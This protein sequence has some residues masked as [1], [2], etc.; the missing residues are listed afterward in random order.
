MNAHILATRATSNPRPA[1]RRQ[2]RAYRPAMEG[3]EQRLQLSAQ[4]VGSAVSNIVKI[5]PPGGPTGNPLP[6]ALP[7]AELAVEAVNVQSLGNNQFEVTAT[8]EDVPP[9]PP[10]LPNIVGIGGGGTTPISGLTYP[11]GGVLTITRSD[12]GTSLSLSSS[13]TIQSSPDPS[14]T[15]ASMPIP[16]LAPGQTVKLS[17]TTTGPALFTATAGPKIYLGRPLPF[18]VASN[19]TLSAIADNLVSHTLPVNTATLAAISTLNNAI[20][21]TIIS[22]DGN[23]SSIFIPGIVNEQFKLPGKSVSIGV[24]PISHTV[25]FTTNNLNS[26][27]AALTYEQGGLAITINFADGTNALVSN[28]VIAPNIGVTNLQV[29]IVFPLSYNASGQFF[30]LNSPKVTV[31]GNWSADGVLGP[32]FN[33]LLP[34]INAAIESA[35]IS[36]LQ[37]YLGLISFQL[38]KPLHAY[39]ASGRIVSANIQQ[40]QM[41]LTIETP[42]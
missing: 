9:L 33:L 41:L 7:E 19:S 17:T 12:G 24:G 3:M 37:P 34:N 30:N 22:L 16:S 21:N 38:D 13:N 15:L 28:S 14:Q 1:S 10:H 31:T 39:T 29:K 5:N 35:V 25:T 8:L 36:T 42:S 26:T 23:N 18:L 2:K 11:G 32:V 20:K 6:V 40:D 27:T 4:A